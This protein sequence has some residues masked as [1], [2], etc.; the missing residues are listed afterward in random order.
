MRDKLANLR[1]RDDIVIK[2]ADKGSA[3]V[4]M[5]IKFYG[6]EA[7]FKSDPTLEIAKKGEASIQKMM[8]NG[9]IDP[10]IGPHLLH[11]DPKPGRF[12]ILP[13]IHN[14]GNPYRTIISGNG[15][16]TENISKSVDLLIQ[17]LVSSLDSHVQDTTD[18]IRKIREIQNLSSDIILATL[19]VSSLYTNIPHE[20]GISACKSVF[21]PIRGKTQ[22]KLMHLILINNNLEFE[23]CPNSRYRRNGHINCSIVC[24][25]IHG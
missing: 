18:F 22:T 6:E 7:R 17:P 12:Y 21:Q 16:A 9:S 25:P 10:E 23:K 5:G 20:E 1:K 8:Q 3:N 13:N 19:D 2:P 11:V 14:A 4:A 24:Q 15:T